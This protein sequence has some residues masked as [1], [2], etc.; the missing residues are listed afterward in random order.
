MKTKMINFT[1]KKCGGTYKLDI[2]D[3]TR[4]EVEASLRKQETF[5]CPGH[6]FELTNPLNFWTLDWESLTE[7]EKI[8][9]EKWL[10]DLKSKYKEVYN[11]QELGEKHEDIH[12]S[13]G[14]CITT[15]KETG[16]KAVFDFATS[17]EGTRYYFL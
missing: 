17:P 13:Y 12:F 2:G 10:Q 5:E 1:C 14:F 8:T 4:E 6:H 9:E 3:K 7:S 11:K 16:E 15:N